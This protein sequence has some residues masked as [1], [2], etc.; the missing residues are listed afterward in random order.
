LVVGFGFIQTRF[1]L[2][3]FA[4]LREIKLLAKA[5][6]RKGE[7]KG[8]F[9]KPN[10]I[11]QTLFIL[12]LTSFFLTYNSILTYLPKKINFAGLYEISIHNLFINISFFILLPRTKIMAKQR[13][14]FQDPE[15]YGL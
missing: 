9:V 6:R 2:C 8:V 3:A 10:L 14:F 4:P 1:L 5:Q 15:E 12:M 7:S 11:A 13:E